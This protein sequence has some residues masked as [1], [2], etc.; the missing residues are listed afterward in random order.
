MENVY[1]LLFSNLENKMNKKQ[2]KE[3][4]LERHSTSSNVHMV[5]GF[6]LLYSLR[7]GTTEIITT[8]HTKNMKYQ[9]K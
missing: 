7:P 6:L 4:W 3:N 9:S 8:Q 1:F 2:G 5:W